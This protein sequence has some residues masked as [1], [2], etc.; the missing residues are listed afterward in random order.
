[1]APHAG[2]ITVRELVTLIARAASV[3]APRLAPMSQRLLSTVGLVVP[4]IREIAEVTYQFT[5]PFE[6]DARAAA[7]DASDL[8]VS[9]TPWPEAAAETVGWWRARAAVAA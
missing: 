6:I 3:E 4:S 2:S 7:A 8:A 9:A 1:M 5:R